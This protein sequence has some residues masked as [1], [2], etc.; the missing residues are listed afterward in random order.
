MKYEVVL[1]Q[2]YIRPF[3]LNLGKNLHSFTF[4]RIAPAKM[5]RGSSV[6]LPSFEK[7]F[8]R[9]KQRPDTILRRILGIPNIRVRFGGEGDL[10]FTYG[11][12][13]IGN[14]PYATYIETG[15]ALYGYDI[16]IAKNRLAQ[17]LVGFLAT[18]PSCLQLIFLSEAAR[19]SFFTSVTYPAY[20][21]RKLEAKSTVI[22]PVPITPPAHPRIRKNGKTLKLFFPGTFYIK[23]G[24]EIAHAYERL[25]QRYGE[26]VE[27]TI[28]TALHM[29]RPED[30]SYLESLPGLN[31]KDA[32]LNEQEM[33]Q[34]YQ[35]HDL[36]LLPTF[37][38]GFGL[39]LIEALAY[40]LPVLITDQYATGEMAKDGWNGFVYPNHPLKD[41]DS[42]TFKM[43]GKYSQPRDFYAALFALQASGGLRPVEDF[44]VTSVE[45]FLNNPKLLEEFSKNSLALY[46]EKFDPRKSSA[47]LEQIFLRGVKKIRARS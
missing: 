30:R 40:G 47:E 1:F 41:Y 20:F 13:V 23:G 9:H 7:E 11:S 32:K 42:T 25:R 43:Y 14:K 24:L 29:I 33:I 2:P 16:G 34:A 37:R 26:R 38:E 4:K 8:Q 44:L 12:L 39:V 28:V 19:K 17:L 15:L 46:K 45:K 35:D 31:L 36:F 5:G 3:V 6:G 21:R 10:L 18:R 22:Y 27:L